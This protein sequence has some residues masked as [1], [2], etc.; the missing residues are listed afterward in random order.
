MSKSYAAIYNQTSDS[1]SLEQRYFLKKETTRGT[2]NPPT[3]A[4]FLYTLAGGGITA[5][6]A[7]SSS[8]HRSG[9]HN[10]NIIKEKRVEEFSFNTYFNY[11]AAA[12]NGDAAIDTAVK[13]LWESALGYTTVGGGSEFIAN[14]SVAP[15]VTFTILEVGDAFAKQLI[16]GFIE[17]CEIQLPGDG[18]AQAAWSG[19][20]GGVKVV[21]IG[22]SV[23]DNDGANTIT[24]AT[25]EGVRFPVGAQVMLI[26]ANGTTRSADTPDGSPRSVVS[27]SGDVVTLSGAVLA[28]AD[29]SGLNA[30]IYLTYYEPVTPVGIDAPQTG[31]VG[32][33]S[34]SLLPSGY[35][36]RSLT[37]AIANNHERVD[38]CFGADGLD[39]PYF[40]PAGRLDVTVT[41]ELNMSKALV[42]FY[43]RVVA[44][45][46]VDIL[47]VLG[48]ATGRRYEFEMP[49]VIFQIPAIEVPE[50]GS[51]PVSFDGLGYQVSLES[52]DE[53]EVRV[54]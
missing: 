54:A 17:S 8:Q 43:N 39:S 45:E 26:E 46:P 40:I 1:N 48:A 36:F 14:P 38:Y 53:L 18:Q 22:K 4:D 30:P 11:D 10:N 6:Q 31:L 2:F 16:G 12:A 20:G 50:T 51:I 34:S 7:L 21:G 5:S 3:G 29:G 23:I 33:I 52:A 47:A 19:A 15:N 13:T 37:I 44:N 25:G 27:V 42:G 32:D 28:D 41:A 9:R 35:C 49:R 24:L